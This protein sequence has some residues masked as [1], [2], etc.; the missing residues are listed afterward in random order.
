[1]VRTDTTTARPAPSA[2]HTAVV[3][4]SGLVHVYCPTCA[5]GSADPAA[6]CGHRP[7]HPVSLGP[8]RARRSRCI[9]CNDLI[10]GGCPAC[11]AR[12]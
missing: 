5:R 4:G 8:T 2:N 11:G 9:V 7:G 3:P 10:D 1:M 6:L 12:P